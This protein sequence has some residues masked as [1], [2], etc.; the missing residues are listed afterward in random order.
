MLE[1]GDRLEVAY[2][3][4][5]RNLVP[6][7]ESIWST[8]IGHDGKGRMLKVDNLPGE[9]SNKRI[10]FSEY[11]YT[12]IESIICMKQISDNLVEVDFAVPS[13]YI[14]ALNNFLAFQANAGRVRDNI[15]KMLELYLAEKVAEIMNLLED[16]YQKRNTIIHGKK[17]PFRVEEQL[18]LIPKVKGKGEDDFGWNSSMS[19]QDDNSELIFVYDFYKESLEEIASLYNRILYNLAEPINE[20]IKVYN[21]SLRFPDEQNAATHPSASNNESGTN[22]GGFSGYSGY[23]GYKVL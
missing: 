8:F 20:I 17:L 21:I 7:Y 14:S 15:K 4:T 6:A 22:G 19:W 23:D 3:E 11:N 2:I 18:M 12:C 10:S 5:I 13:S 9:E 1:K 16:L